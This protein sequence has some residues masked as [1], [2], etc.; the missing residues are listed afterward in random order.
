MKPMRNILFLSGIF[1][2]LIIF[3]LIPSLYSAPPTTYQRVYEDTEAYQKQALVMDSTKKQQHREAKRRKKVY[4]EERI[5]S[6]RKVKN[7]NPKM[8]SRSVQYFPKEELIVVLDSANAE[9]VKEEVVTSKVE[10]MQTSKVEQVETSF[11][12]ETDST[13]ITSK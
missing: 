8:F 5:S 7:L 6:R 9:I 13:K 4:K 1:C 12:I 2:S 3:W 11:E 10:E